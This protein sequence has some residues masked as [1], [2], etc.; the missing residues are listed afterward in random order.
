VNRTR[1]I[2]RSAGILAGLASALLASII[3]A[4]AAF[5]T[6][7]PGPAGP[8]VPAAENPARVHAALADG[9]PA[10][11]ITLIAVR[12]AILAAAIAVLL[13][14]AQAARRQATP[15]AA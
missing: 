14:R 11:Q 8:A 9:M 5:A 6:T 10:W 4:P 12:A 2:R 13:T 3:T 15:T 7:S 1:R